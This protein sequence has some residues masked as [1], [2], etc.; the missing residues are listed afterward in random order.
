MK[1]SYVTIGNA[2]D[3][4]NW[5]GLEFYIAK[6]LEQH[7]GEVNYI[8]NLSIKKKLGLRP[9]QIL[10]R[11]IGQRYD[12][13]RNPFFAAQCSQQVKSLLRPDTDIVFSPGSVATA[14]LETNKPKVIY[15]DATFAGLLNFYVYNYCSDTIRK[16]H[17]L[18]QKALDSASL[19]I[20]SS[21]YAAQSAIQNYHVEPG[22]VKVVPF[23]ANIKH[24]FSLADIKRIVLNRSRKECNLLFLGVD[25]KRKG[26]G[27]AVNVARRLNEIGVKTSLHIVGIRDIPF[28]TLP[29][30]VLNHGFISKSTKEGEEKLLNLMA[31]CH[32]LLVPTKAE[33]YGLVFC[34]AN[35]LALPSVT[36]NV[37]G[38]ST[39]I[40]NNINGKMFGLSDTEE[41]YADYIASVFCNPTAYDQL[42]LSSYNEY[43]TRLNWQ[44][45]GNTISRLLKEL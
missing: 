11:L 13:V 16:G 37:G 14:L 7:V 27:L 26:G 39:I 33:S 40:K 31:K 29:G 6:A 35:S 2:L 18:E 23:G 41:V 4:H 1:I 38:I 30:F 36:T 24:N 32:F 8:G 12:A 22:K 21:D 10:Y 28:R 3:V 5:S 15:S 44:V 42:A 17:Y 25:W 20:Y 43:K 9:K 45:A 19:A 34:E